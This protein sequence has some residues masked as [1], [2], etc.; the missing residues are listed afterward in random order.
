METLCGQINGGS[1]VLVQAEG[2][3]LNTEQVS[4]PG[5]QHA[6]CNKI[7]NGVSRLIGRT[8]LEQGIGPEHAICELLIDEGF[9]ARVKDRQKAL[10]IVGVVT[11]NLIAE[12]KSIHMLP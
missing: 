10:N 11:D 8:E 1:L 4:T 9:D 2:L 7:S 3:P 12:R 6:L 5:M